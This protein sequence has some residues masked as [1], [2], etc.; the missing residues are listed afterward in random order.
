MIA[1]QKKISNFKDLRVWQESIN[2][3]KEVYQL[4]ATLPKEELYGLASQMKRAAVSLPSNI[5]EG[6]SRQ[7]RA[8]FRQFVFIAI[9]SLAELETQLIIA[10]NLSFVREAE[11]T[12]IIEKINHLR[13]MLL[14]L[15]RKL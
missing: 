11:V 14:T 2:L 12:P 9:G 10:L 4:C 13:A 5:A 1:G 7:H 3:V 15:G 6:N 8:E